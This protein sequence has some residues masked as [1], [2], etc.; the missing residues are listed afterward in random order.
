MLVLDL[1]EMIVVKNKDGKL[2]VDALKVTQKDN[3]QKEQKPAKAMA[4]RI[5]QATLN[6]GRVIVKDYTNGEQPQIQVYDIGVNKTFRNIKGAEQFAALVMVQGMGP[7]ALKS[8][9]I[10]GAA[11]FLGVAFLPAGVAG[12]MFS[13][14]S[15][16][17]E[18]SVDADRAYEA[19]LAVLK[20]MGTVEAGNKPSSIKANVDGANI[21]VEIARKEDGKVQVKISARK[22]LI[23]RPETA[24]GIMYQLSQGL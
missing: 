21:S 22:Y 13:K 10:Y 2:N 5:D 12:A 24:N 15:S 3:D 6:L 16:I 8:A 19:V 20:K 7:T 1:K 9:A 23:P 11:G 18:F 17:K 14:D 4:L